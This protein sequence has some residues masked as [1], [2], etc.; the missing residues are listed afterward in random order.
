M[1]QHNIRLGISLI[2]CGLIFVV[3][4]I[5]LLK[6][7]IK[8][9]HWYGFRI[10]KAFE[11]EENW[12]KINRY[13]AQRFIIWSVAIIIS[14]VV[15]FLLQPQLAA[16]IGLSPLIIFVIIPIIETLLYARKL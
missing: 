8:M 16:K 4:S 2:A 5:P 9:N 13:G 10:G 7:A 15:I 14:G 11:S 6:G 12:Y 3:M 1:Q